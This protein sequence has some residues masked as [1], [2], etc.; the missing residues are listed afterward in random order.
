MSDACARGCETLPTS[1]A[2]KRPRGALGWSLLLVLILWRPEASAGGIFLDNCLLDRL[3][4]ASGDLPVSVLRQA[5]E[6][7]IR[8]A[9]HLQRKDDGDLLNSPDE[10]QG[11][12]VDSHAHQDSVVRSR[13]QRELQ[14]IDNP[15]AIT[16]HK[17]NYFLPF[18]Y[19]HHPNEAPFAGREGE[20]EPFEMKF[21][22]SL[23]YPMAKGVLFKKSRLFFAYTNLSFWQ[24]YN[25]RFSSP[26][27]ETNHEPEMFLLIPHNWSLLGWHHQLTA[28]GFS[29][30]SNGQTGT[31]SRSWNR[32][33][34]NLIF[35]RNNLVVSLKPWY[36]IPEK[37]KED[38]NDSS[39]DDN[40]DIEDFMGQGELRLLYKKG[41]DTY[42]M[43][44][45]NNFATDSRGAVEISWSFPIGKRFKNR[46][47]GFVQ[48]F[49][50]YGESLIDYNA[51]V[52]R[53]S[54]GVA[55]S[56]WL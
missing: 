46:L 15:F 53:I 26:F 34:A 20:L 41:E 49:N 36:R 35:E 48:Y 29:H 5:C 43:M 9:N 14:T 42:S 38:I 4:D 11:T 44:L 30:Q 45:R 47:K 13:L 33:Y 22:F 55:I 28:I 16:P 32:I 54:V 12:E 1:K 51:S 2:S 40:P 25:S 27:R 7:E 10:S 21:Q 31:V 3:K 50:G 18:T 24:A 56:D 6:R 17:P 23:K 37:E 39:G 19:N 52:N 8:E